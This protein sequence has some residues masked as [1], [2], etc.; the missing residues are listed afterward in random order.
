M[1]ALS[2]FRPYLSGP[3]L[4]G[5]AGRYSDIDLQLF[6]DDI[7]TLELLFLN[8]GV[9]YEISDTRRFSGDEARSV[10]MMRFEW[11]GIPVTVAVHASK[12]ERTSLKSTLN[13]RPI[14]RAGL[15]AVEALVQGVGETDAV[16]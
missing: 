14:E 5:T 13:G 9:P 1:R 16:E 12:D 10:A 7:K 11:Q 15:P 4:K 6:T 3:V 8:R 2:Q